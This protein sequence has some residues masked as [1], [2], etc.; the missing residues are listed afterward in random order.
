MLFEIKR[1][2][3]V[4]DDELKPREIDAVTNFFFVLRPSYYV[5]RKFIAEKRLEKKIR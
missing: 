2:D 4:D 1:N 3:D 5:T